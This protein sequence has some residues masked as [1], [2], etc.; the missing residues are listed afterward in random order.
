MPVFKEAA[1]GDG[2]LW[3]QNLLH[4]KLRDH[5]QHLLKT[6][7]YC[8]CKI[9][10]KS[11]FISIRWLR[12]NALMHVEIWKTGNCVEVTTITTAR[13]S[14]ADSPIF[15]KG[16]LLKTG[17]FL[18]CPVPHYSLA[19]ASPLVSVVPTGWGSIIPKRLVPAHRWKC[20][21]QSTGF[22]TP[23]IDISSE[24]KKSLRSS[25][26]AERGRVR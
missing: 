15:P 20:K 4:E 26:Q 2:L 17:F 24:I 23:C 11:I 13:A 16:L 3:E 12:Q 19:V 6:V 21:G 7:A 22:L 14:A 10:F 9:F 1:A 5:T 18:I 8:C 25:T